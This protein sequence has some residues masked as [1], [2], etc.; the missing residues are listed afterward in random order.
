MGGER[1]PDDRRPGDRQPGDR[2][3]R[4]REGLARRAPEATAGFVHAALDRAIQGGGP[5][6]SAATVAV[7]A[8][9]AGGRRDAVAQLD[10]AVTQVIETH[11]RLAGAQGFATNVGGLV[12][13]AVTVPSNVAGLALVQCRM[14]AAVLHLRGYDLD[15]PRVR[16]AVLAT[17]LGEE[18][19][20]ALI[21]RSQLPG[22]PM[23]LATAPVHDPHLDAV[24]AAEVAAELLTK[25][26]GKRL[27]ST[28][29]RRVPVVG[30]LVGAGTDG[31]A[32]WQVGRYADREF[33]AR[34]R[35]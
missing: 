29:G 18:K 14:V 25:V 2:I 22:T 9:D 13:M 19:V 4:F 5:L 31:F 15:D 16:N 8:L 21:D 1:Q 35:R 12:T 30:G 26:A 28:V 24:M 27:A 11:V 6:D 23:A 32:T 3:R 20:L 33:L 34:R 17:L 10:A 7:K